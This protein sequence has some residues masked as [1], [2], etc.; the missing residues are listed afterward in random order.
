MEENKETVTRTEYSVRN[1]SI[2]MIS[3]ILAMIMGYL[4]RVVF[5]HTLSEDYVGLNGLFTDIIRVLSFSEMGIGTAITY[6][7]YRPVAEGDI[8]KQKTLM[9]LFRNFYRLAATLAAVLGCLLIPFMPLLIKDYN[10]VGHLTLIYLLYLINTICSYLLIYKKTLLDA[11]QKMYIGVFFQT[12]SWIIKDVLEMIVLVLWH[13]FVLFLVIEIVS[14]LLCN[15]VISRTADRCCPYLRDREVARLPKEE[16]KEIFANIRAMV[17]HKVGTVVVNNT[18]NLVLSACVGLL[19]VG[20]YS[21]YSL[22]LGSVQQL[23]GQLYQGITASVGNLG[24]TEDAKQVKQVFDVTVFIGQWLYGVAFI[25]L[26]ELL[27]PV[28]EFSFGEQYLFSENIVFVLCLNFYIAGL[29]RPALTFR[30]S[31][32]LFWYDRYKSILEAGMNIVLSLILVRYMGT[33]GVFLGTSL[34]M[35]LTSF[36]VEPYVLYKYGFKSSCRD[37]FLHQGRYCAL[38]AIV[39]LITDYVCGAAAVLAGN[40]FAEIFIRLVLCVVLSDSLLLLIYCRTDHFKDVMNIVKSF[41][42]KKFRQ[43]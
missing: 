21:N 4:L 22:V 19:S 18:D 28:I 2:A 39:W 41:I 37:Y 40:L 14:T 16:K 33:I 23:L 13:D 29:R 8:E 26:F 42:K 43:K 7:L 32:G 15:I 11:Q 38:M 24:V 31:M 27:N 12:L 17:M 34:S 6:A 20:S 5:T 25:C 35:G 9:R 1:T 36:W 10:H 3:R 30:N